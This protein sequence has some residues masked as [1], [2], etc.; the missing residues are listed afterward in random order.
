ME[1]SCPY[2][3][4]AFQL[5][6]VR[7]LI[8]SFL[9]G[10]FLAPRWAEVTRIRRLGT[11]GWIIWRG[12]VSLA[13]G[14]TCL[15]KFLRRFYE[16]VYTDFSPEILIAYFSFCAPTF[17]LETGAVLLSEDCFYFNNLFLREV[18]EDSFLKGFKSFTRLMSPVPFCFQSLRLTEAFTLA[19]GEFSL[20]LFRLSF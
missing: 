19:S 14:E 15:L 17:F 1:G 6:W 7:P 16:G 3:L 12:L 9:D 13:L 20:I 2:S 10:G 18:G 4:R 11:G 5:S 8:L